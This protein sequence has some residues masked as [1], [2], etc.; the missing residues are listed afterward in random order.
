MGIT[1][2]IKYKTAV[3]VLFVLLLILI[4]LSGIFSH[5]LWKPDEPRVAEIGREMWLNRQFVLPTLNREPF[6]EKPPLYWWVMSVSYELFGVSDGSA[7]LPSALFGFL[8]LLFTYLIGKRVG[9]EK[10]GMFA[11]FVLATLTEFSIITHRCLVDNALVFFVTLG[12]YGFFAGYTASTPRGK[13]MGYELMAVASGLAFL[14]KGLVGPG[15]IVAPPLLVLLLYRDFKEL[16][17]VLPMTGV[18]ALIFL[19]IVAPWLVGLYHTGGWQAIR[20]YLLQNTLGRILPGAVN[21]Y[22]GGHRH[23]FFYYFKKLPQDFMPW[24]IALPAVLSFWMHPP[25]SLDT[26]SRRA[27][28]AALLLFAAGFLLL[29]IPET[30][31]GLYLVPIYPVLAIGIGGWFAHTCGQGYPGNTLDRWTFLVLL[32]LFALVPL[33]VAAGTGIM[34]LTGIG[35]KGIPL[36]PVI[37]RL[38]PMLVLI[39]PLGIVAFLFL[40]N[41]AVRSFRAQ[42]RPSCTILVTTALALLFVYQEGA[43][44]VMDPAKNFHLFTEKMK[45]YLT[46]GTPIAGYKISELTR[47]II[48]FDTGEYVATFTDPHNLILFLRT[49]RRALI[50]IPKEEVNLLPATLKATLEFLAGQNYSRHLR[51]TLY[52]LKPSETGPRAPLYPKSRPLPSPPR[53]L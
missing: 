46:R 1:R 26:A 3:K 30:K 32:T 8:T 41:R 31:R 13:W 48:P 22:V 18:G 6:L 9:G 14:S 33:G 17:R 12:Y 21:H 4:S 7:R 24:I 27:G 45:P 34:V 10:T 44:R 43:T 47:A 40:A 23:S 28:R 35:P 2:M 25:N 37:R 49:H 39:V 50:V 53:V 16:R 52:R 36:A 20:E 19:L 42:I 11:A 15:L 5:H 29:S 51:V 38:T